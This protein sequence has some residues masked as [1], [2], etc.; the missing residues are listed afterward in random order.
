GLR[1]RK[2]TRHHSLKENVAPGG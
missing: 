2:K 1:S